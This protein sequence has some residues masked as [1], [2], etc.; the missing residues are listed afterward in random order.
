MI[1]RRQSPQS[2]SVAEGLVESVWAAKA[3]RRGCRLWLRRCSSAVGHQKLLD[4]RSPS[5]H[6]AA[7][8]HSR[9]ALVL[10]PAGLQ[11]SSLLCSTSSW[12]SSS[13]TP[14]SFPEG[15]RWVFVWFWLRARFPCESEIWREMLTKPSS[16]TFSQLFVETQKKIQLQAKSS[17]VWVY[18]TLR[19]QWVKTTAVC[20]K[21]F[22][23]IP[24]GLR[25]MT[26]RWNMLH[27]NRKYQTEKQS[28]L[29]GS[30]RICGWMKTADIVHLLLLSRNIFPFKEAHLKRRR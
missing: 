7:S 19:N 14:F 10:F 12:C 24:A 15:S 27:I 25:P 30:E 29:C 28:P 20:L 8:L 11:V 6:I 1:W 16:A 23:V 13:S 3:D 5:L 18:R 26:D 22:L 4:F 2:A 9:S 17:R 21:Q